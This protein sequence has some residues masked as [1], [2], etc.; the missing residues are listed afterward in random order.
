MAAR[1]GAGARWELAPGDHPHEAMQLR[2]DSS[3]A[4][5]QL[6]WQPRWTLERCLDMVLDW[7]RAHARGEDMQ[8][9]T[10]EQIRCFSK[11]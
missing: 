11:T 6:S 3:K 1:W 5:A 2:L 4:R 10:L 8:K 9:V 7:Y